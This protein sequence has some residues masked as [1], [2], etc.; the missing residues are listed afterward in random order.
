MLEGLEG[1]LGGLLPAPDA[2]GRYLGTEGH[3]AAGPAGLLPP[4]EL[5][6]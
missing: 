1:A 3:L 5:P 2:L 6:C 4:V